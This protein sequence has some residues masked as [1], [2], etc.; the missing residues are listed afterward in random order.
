[1]EESYDPAAAFQNGRLAMNDGVSDSCGQNLT[2]DYPELEGKWMIVVPPMG[3]ERR[4]AFSGAGYWGLLRGTERVE[5]SLRLIQFLAR[6]ENM[7]K[8]AER[9]A[10]V[11]AN[12][13]V[14]N[15][16]FC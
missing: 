1:M 8:F 15:A 11:S 3:P 16:D 9:T 7:L 2:R 6:D 14:M 5:E 13:A 12:K 4:V 10:H